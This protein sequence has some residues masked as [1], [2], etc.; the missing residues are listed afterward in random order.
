MWSIF[1]EELLQTTETAII[2]MISIQKIIY[3]TSMVM[4]RY[5][6]TR[7]ALKQG[8]LSEGK[9]EL[10]DEKSDTYDKSTLIDILRKIIIDM[11][12]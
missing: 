2:A 5:E 7:D 9:K 10:I 3:W 6:I 11:K 1:I 4:K 12:R 8:A